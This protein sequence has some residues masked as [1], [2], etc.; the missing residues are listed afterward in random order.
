M[1]FYES[2]F[3]ARQDLPAPQVEQMAE[4][5]AGI[6]TANGGEVAKKEFWGLRNL[7][8]RIKKNR[9]GH[10]VLMNLD[11]PAAA[12]AEMER[13]E[14][15]NEDILRIMTIRV[16]ELEE[17]PSAVLRGRDERDDRRGGRDRGERR[18]RDDRPRR[19][20]RPE[21]SERA[22]A[23]APAPEAASA[24]EGDE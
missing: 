15:L 5:F 12:V 1:P 4:L 10:Y 20:D 18:D 14:R 9:K 11:A 2:I 6:V 19:D 8:Y 24:S 23:A 3:I 21:R 16:D 17:G 7:T 13:N 22:P